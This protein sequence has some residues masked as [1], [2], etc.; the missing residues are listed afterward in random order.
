MRIFG[1]DI[2]LRKNEK[3]V[4]TRKEHVD[5]FAPCASFF[6]FAKSE[7]LDCQKMISNRLSN[8]EY[9][10]KPAYMATAEIF[11]FIQSNRL[12]LIRRLFYD[13][14][15][16]INT[17]TFEFVDT[18]GRETYRS[19]DGRM[20]FQLYEDEI[21]Q[22]SET[23][24]ATG[25]S[26]HYFLCDKIRFLNI[27]NSSDM[28]LI[29]NYGAMGIVSPESDNS[30]TGAE[31]SEDDIKELQSRYNRSYGIT[32][33]KWSLM[34]VPRPTKYTPIQLPIAQLKL[35][36]K[37]MYLLKAI[38]AAFGIPKE[39]SVYFESS[40]YANRHE[41]E[42]DFYSSTITAWADLFLA[43]AESMY[44]NIRKR[45]HS[46]SSAEFWYDFV[47]VFALQESQREEREKA[48]ADLEFWQN[49]KVTL[50]EYSE[51]ANARINNLIES[52]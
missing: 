6:D 37:R 45:K 30:V 52:L 42:L 22:T 7:I 51:T 12:Q 10:A 33:G 40:K 17:C 18:V 21:L 16:I 47:G 4:R 36:E 38:Y 3:H 23:F 29:E 31:Y 15:V 48:K 19:W 9:F 1:Y 14:Y 34:F 46:L 44:R 20:C 41:A 5:F 43:I 26:D 32:L 50:P 25:H 2:R 27:V 24:E 8:A 11:D 35:D 39:L 13:G 49:V 28:N